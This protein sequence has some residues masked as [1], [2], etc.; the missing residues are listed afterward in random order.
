MTF[1]QIKVVVW[2][3]QLCGATNMQKHTEKKEDLCRP[4][5]DWV[6]VHL[7]DKERDQ[8]VKYFCDYIIQDI[9]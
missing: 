1:H 2:P 4:P 8:V 7:Y 3:K 9:C 5:H 6:F